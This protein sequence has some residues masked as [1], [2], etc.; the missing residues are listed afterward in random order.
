MALNGNLAVERERDRRGGERAKKKRRRML[1]LL[2]DGGEDEYSG[3]GWLR[4]VEE[5]DNDLHTQL[6]LLRLAGWHL[7]WGLLLAKKKPYQTSYANC[8]T[9]SSTTIYVRSQI[10][11]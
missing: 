8:P 5:G 1:V 9:K 10:R 11:E 7:P 2:S 4:L 3:G 6:R